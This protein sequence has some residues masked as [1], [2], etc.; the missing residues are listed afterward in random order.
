MS[1]APFIGTGSSICQGRVEVE[2]Y[3]T[4]PKAKCQRLWGWGTPIG[5]HFNLPAARLGN[6]RLPVV[7]VPTPLRL[8]SQHGQMADWEGHGGG[9]E[10]PAPW[11]LPHPFC[12]QVSKQYILGVPSAP[13]PRS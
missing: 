3:T 13:D 11:A 6:F 5:A 10:M 4:H 9:W 12:L 7:T 2:E 8:D 1:S